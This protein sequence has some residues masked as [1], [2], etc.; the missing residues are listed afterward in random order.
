MKAAFLD[1]LQGEYVKSI[2]TII[3]NDIDILKNFCW[4]TLFFGLV[5]HFKLLLL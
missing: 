1:T 5:S 4:P 3:E 2:N